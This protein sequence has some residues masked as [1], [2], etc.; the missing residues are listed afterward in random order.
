VVDAHSQALRLRSR[1][2]K[3]EADV[4][5]VLTFDEARRIAVDVA[6]VPEFFGGRVSLDAA[7]PF[8]RNFPRG[9]SLNI[10]PNGWK[11]Q[12]PQTSLWFGAFFLACI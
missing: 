5:K 9:D 2:T 6:K 8:G 4:A 3:A 12:R 10:S 11:T 7:A 1:E